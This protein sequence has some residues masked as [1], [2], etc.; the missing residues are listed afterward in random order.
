MTDLDRNKQ[1][2]I[3]SLQVVPAAR[4]RVDSK[5]AEP[6]AGRAR[7]DRELPEPIRKLLEA[8]NRPVPP[9]STALY[10]LLE[11]SPERGR[12]LVRQAEQR[13]LV[14]I[15]TLSGGRGAP[16]RLPELTGL[17]QNALAELGGSTPPPLTHGGWLHNV[18]A[19]ALNDVYRRAG[20]RG[21]FE[22]DAQGHR[23][24]AQFRHS[25]GQVHLV[26]IGVTNPD[27]EATSV[28]TLVHALGEGHP[29]IVVLCLDRSFADRVEKKLRALKVPRA[30]VTTR[31]IGELLKEY[32]S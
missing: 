17:G 2:F 7:S 24:D 5:P 29:P 8:V 26:Q 10:E 4:F 32:Y 23:I 28:A 13:G 20:W 22:V 31:L 1:R 30:N 9:K 25:D 14:R 6:P 19:A 3:D 18:A 15:H 27:R 11:V 12:Q 16:L 21:K